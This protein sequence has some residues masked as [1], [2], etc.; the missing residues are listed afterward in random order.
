MVT[1]DG[2]DQTFYVI[3]VNGVFIFFHRVTDDNLWTMFLCVCFYACNACN[4]RSVLDLMMNEGLFHKTGVLV[5][6]ENLES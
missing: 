5:A 1:A 4:N 6:W 3:D 2:C